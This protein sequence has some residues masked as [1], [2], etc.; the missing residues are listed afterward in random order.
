VKP[1]PIQVPARVVRDRGN[2]RF[3]LPPHTTLEIVEHPRVARVPASPAHAIGLLEWQGRRIPLIDVA[4]LV[5][6]A[7]ARA[8]PARYAL[9]VAFQHAPG[10]DV[11][12]GALALDELP[13]TTSVD[14]ASACDVPAEWRDLA[15]SCFEGSRVPTPIVDTARLFAA[16]PAPTS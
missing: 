8:N 1:D 16:G 12:H 14:D 5:R 11:E 6:A 7:G 9:V 13:E 3:A 10:A 2:L 4:V 15:V